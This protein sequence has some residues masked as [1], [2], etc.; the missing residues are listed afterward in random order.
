LRGREEGRKERRK[1]K[2]DRDRNNSVEGRRKGKR[3]KKRNGWVR[4]TLYL[5]I[6]AQSGPL[7]RL[8]EVRQKRLHGMKAC[9][10]EQGMNESCFK[11]SRGIIESHIRTHIYNIF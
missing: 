10:N 2:R 4:G 7:L 1:K 6:A 11:D 3:E 5:P 9:H 8:G